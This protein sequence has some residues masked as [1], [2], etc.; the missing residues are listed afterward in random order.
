MNQKFWAINKRLSLSITVWTVQ[1]SS[2]C[3]SEHRNTNFQLLNSTNSAIENPTFWFWWRL[4]SGK[5]SADSIRLDGTV[6]C[7][8]NGL[9]TIQRS[10]SCFQWASDRKW[11]WYNL[12]MQYAIIDNGVLY[13]VTII[14][15]YLTNAIET[16]TVAPYFP[17]L[18]ISH[19][20]HTQRINKVTKL[21]RV[22]SN[23]LISVLLTTKCFRW[24]NDSFR[25]I[26]WNFCI[27]F[28]WKIYRLFVNINQ[29]QCDCFAINH[30]KNCFI[31]L[32]EA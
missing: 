14:F 25:F 15:T 13:L 31:V 17:L 10:V 18:T 22:L 9:L 26:I 11:I 20:S 7:I 30:L 23:H 21:F 27:L 5:L 3:C 29:N 16:K 24:C 28:S 19:Q 6:S 12:S 2:S 4:S 32:I 8:E 1:N